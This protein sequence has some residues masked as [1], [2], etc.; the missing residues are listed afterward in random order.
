MWPEPGRLWAQRFAKRHN[1]QSVVLHGT[2]RDVVAEQPSSALAAWINVEDDE[3]V[4]ANM[5]VELIEDDD[6]C[7]AEKDDTSSQ[8]KNSTPT[9][10]KRLRPL[11][12]ASETFTACFPELL[13]LLDRGEEPDQATV[14]RKFAAGVLPLLRLLELLPEK[15]FDPSAIRLTHRLNAMANGSKAYA[16]KKR[17]QSSLLGF[18]RGTRERV[19]DILAEAAVAEA[20]RS[21]SADTSDAPL[22]K[23]L[24][25]QRDD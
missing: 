1:L 6:D 25:V 3:E 13:S 10:P 15:S 9:A 18:V 20:V 7:V 16:K 12:T 21:V 17:K 5:L 19:D 23:V 2:A 24:A 8:P 11:Q 14:R 4:Q 22:N